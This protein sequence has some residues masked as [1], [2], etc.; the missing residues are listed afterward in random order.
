MLPWSV[1]SLAQVAVR[2]LMTDTAVVDAFVERTRTF[3]ASERRR[4]AEA[5][6]EVS[7]LIVFPSTTSYM[8]LKLLSGHTADAIC[9]H[10]SNQGFLIRN[11]SNFKGLSKQYVR[12]SLKIS[13]TNRMLAEKLHTLMSDSPHPRHISDMSI[14]HQDH[15][16]SC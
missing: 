9:D 12:V 15:I 10:L 1:N 4:F 3:L 11:C 6:A 2:H 14:Q 16:R 8:L 5:M 7:N 13:E